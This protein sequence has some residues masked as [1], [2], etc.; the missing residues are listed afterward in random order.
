LAGLSD[1][2]PPGAKPRL[3]PEQDAQVARLVRE[4]PVLSEDGVVRWRRVDLSRVIETRFGVRLAERSLGALLRHLGFRRLSARPSHPGHD[5]AAQE[6]HKKL[7]RPGRRRDSRTRAG[8]AASNSGGK[9]K[10]VS[11]SKAP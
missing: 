7:R 4:G 6:T 11:A 9:M 10:R 5:A 3:S 1:R 2:I 8:Q